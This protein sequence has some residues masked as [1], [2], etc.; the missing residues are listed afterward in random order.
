MWID[1][2]K[3]RDRV[4]FKFLGDLPFLSTKALCVHA[5]IQEPFE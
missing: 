1:T 3:E 5:Q 2:E 4:R